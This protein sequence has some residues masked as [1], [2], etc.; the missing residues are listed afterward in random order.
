MEIMNYIIKKAFLAERSLSRQPYGANILAG[1]RSSAH[2][3]GKRG[4][5]NSMMNRE[6]ARMARIHGGGPM[7]FRARVVP[8]VVK[9]R[10]AHPPKADKNWTKL[11]NKKEYLYAICSCLAASADADLVKERGHIYD[12]KLPIIIDAKNENIKKTKEFVD[13]LKKTGLEKELERCKKKK[14]RAG[15]GKMRGRRYKKKKGPLVITMKEMKPAK[16]IPSVDVCTPETLTVSLLA[17]GGVPG[18]LLVIT[19]PAMKKL[20]AMYNG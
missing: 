3:H 12:G 11:I 20:E 4:V 17:P 13:V 18:R 2:Y 10:K 14:V 9:G 5:R 1:M 8:H 15:K 6:M 16:N 7:H 19:K